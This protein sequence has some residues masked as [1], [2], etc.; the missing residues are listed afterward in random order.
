MKL[1]ICIAQISHAL[2]E[3]SNTDKHD[4]GSITGLNWE[5]AAKTT[6]G[7]DLE[8]DT[9]CNKRRLLGSVGLES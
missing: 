4:G 7:F 5:H 6:L 3:R 8:A 2:V 1:Y 9:Q